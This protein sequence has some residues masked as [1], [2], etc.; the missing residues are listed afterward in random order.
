MAASLTIV[1]YHYV[2]PLVGSTFPN[3]KGLDLNDFERQ[4][5]YIERH[6]QVVSAARLLDA[7]FGGD[8][9]PD[10]SVLLT[11]DD[12]YSDHYR[13]VLP[14][15]KRRQMSGVFF[16]IGSAVK[17]RIPLLANKL[18]FILAS[19]VDPQSLIKKIESEVMLEMKNLDLLPLA[20]YREQCQPLK[21]HRDPFNIVYIKLMLQSALPE[22]LGSRIVDE[23]FRRYVSSD[24]RA[25]ADDLY[26]SVKELNE[27]ADAGME[28]GSHGYKHYW[29]DSLTLD[30]QE[31]DID[32][33]LTFLEELGV[34][35]DRFLFCF[36]YGAYNQDTLV[37]LKARGC[38]A[39]FTGGGG[40]ADLHEGNL[41]ELPR[42]ETSDLSKFRYTLLK[43]HLPKK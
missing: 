18:H 3:I 37:A 32:L 36:P 17:E 21:R 31:K 30:E 29:L 14:V 9:L 41:L 24:E 39:A 8:A 10:S 34:D 5:D 28:I 19:G 42:V 1:M 22:V 23:L 35:R 33:S 16:P 6:Y 26:L 20:A 38:G 13:Y 40:L 11:F 4:L 25:F 15:L 7:A 27:M 43:K 12:G 2:R